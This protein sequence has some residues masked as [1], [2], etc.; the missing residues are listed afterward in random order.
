MPMFTSS[1]I[2]S[3]ASKWL[4]ITGVFELLLA[5]GFVFGAIAAPDARSGLLLTAVI[6]GAVGIG[7]VFFGIRSRMRA[8]EAKRVLSVGLTGT[9][10]ITSMTQTGMYLNENPQVK[11]DLLVQVPG[12]A[13]YQATRKEFIPLILLGRLS[14]GAPLAVKV[15]PND[16]QDVVIDWENPAPAVV[17]APEQGWWAQGQGSAPGVTTITTPPVVTIG[18]VQVSGPGAP[19]VPAT[20]GAPSGMPSAPFTW[21]TVAA[22]PTGGQAESLAQVQAA[23]QAAGIPAHQ[24]FSFAGQDK[25]QVDQLRAAVRANGIEGT[26]TVDSLQ[27]TTVEIGDEHLFVIESTITV[28]GRPPH[29][30]GPSA[31]MIPKTK[32]GHIAL[33]QTVPVMVAKDNPDLVMFEWEKIP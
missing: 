2:G 30:S 13:P 6:L 1:T 26:A 17:A 23:L 16:P 19:A 14:S 28:P 10:T 25:Y 11:M 24:V 20:P 7:L 15:D 4:I 21:P 31:A 12:R 22:A 32:V 18:G 3:Y 27:D 33:G 29:K 9:A 8:E 5:G